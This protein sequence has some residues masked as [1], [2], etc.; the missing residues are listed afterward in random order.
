MED[1]VIPSLREL[2]SHSE[3]LLTRKMIGRNIAK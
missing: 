1:E 3:S 2:A